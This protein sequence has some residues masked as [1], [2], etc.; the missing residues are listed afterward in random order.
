M[1]LLKIFRKLYK[2]SKSINQNTK[3][4][5][6]SCIIDRIVVHDTCLS[7]TRA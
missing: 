2:K 1:N 7:V 3:V 6:D 5:D 4:Q